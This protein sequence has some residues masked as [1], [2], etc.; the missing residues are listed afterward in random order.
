MATGLRASLDDVPGLTPGERHLLD[1]LL[2][3]ISQ[4]CG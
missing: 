4:A 1:E 3:R 2:Q